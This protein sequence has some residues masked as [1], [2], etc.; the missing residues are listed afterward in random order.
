MSGSDVSPVVVC[1]IIMRCIDHRYAFRDDDAVAVYLQMERPYVQT[2][3]SGMNPL[4]L[5][6][7]F[8]TLV[9]AALHDS[10][11]PH[12]QI[13]KIAIVSHTSGSP[14]DCAAVRAGTGCT[15]DATVW[16][17]LCAYATVRECHPDVLL[18][19]PE[20]YWVEVMPGT[21]TVSACKRDPI[22]D[23]MWEAALPFNSDTDMGIVLRMLALV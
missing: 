5:F 21:G 9:G 14:S 16:G 11:N 18:G 22:T 20:L 4:M 7:A 10:L 12:V 23:E 15:C 1:N 19:I 8:K 3:P 6:P 2:S 13:G 17:I